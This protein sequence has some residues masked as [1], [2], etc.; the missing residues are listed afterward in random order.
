MLQLHS[1]PCPDH[2]DW[3]PGKKLPVAN[4]A[5]SL[6]AWRYPCARTYSRSTAAKEKIKATLQTTQK[7]Q[8]LGEVETETMRE[9]Q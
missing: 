6:T 9:A 4:A 8:K 5:A 2:R 1:C 7:S 3:Q